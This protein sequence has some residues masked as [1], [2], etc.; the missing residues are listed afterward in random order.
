MRRAAL[1]FLLAII[2]Q[3]VCVNAVIAGERKYTV[4]LH[5]ETSIPLFLQ[6]VDVEESIE[7][8]GAHN[9]LYEVSPKTVL[10]L[11]DGVTKAE[12]GGRQLM[13]FANVVPYSAPVDECRILLFNET[14]G[15]LI[16][17]RYL[18]PDGKEYQVQLAYRIENKRIGSDERGDYHK[19]YFIVFNML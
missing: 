8:D 5:N 11:F 16:R 15:S 6:F 2:T 9:N 18:S 12:I 14:K 1:T 3:M 17:F 7:T 10:T 4:V 13:Q 19:T